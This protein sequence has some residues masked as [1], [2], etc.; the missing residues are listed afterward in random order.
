MSDTGK[1]RGKIR[2]VLELTEQQPFYI[3]WQTEWILSLLNNAGVE[4]SLDDF[5]SGAQYF[6]T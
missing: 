5:G 2:L 6:H 4:F 1:V 3:D